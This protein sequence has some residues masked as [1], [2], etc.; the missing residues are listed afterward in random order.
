MLRSADRK[1]LTE[2]TYSAQRSYG[3]GGARRVACLRLTQSCGHPYLDE[4]GFT[5]FGVTTRAHIG[6]YGRLGHQ[7]QDVWS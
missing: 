2:R 1:I 5:P 3:V 7:S 6:R 4:T